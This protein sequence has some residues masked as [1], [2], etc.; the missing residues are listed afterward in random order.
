MRPL[1]LLP[2]LVCAALLTATAACSS[3]NGSATSEQSGATTTAGGSASAAPS[4]A[5]NATLGKVWGANQTGYGEIKPAKIYNGGAGVLG[6]VD[7]VVWSSWGGPEAHAVGTAAW[8]DPTKI[9]ADLFPEQTQVVAFNL[10]TCDGQLMYQNLEWYFPQHGE[11]FDPTHYLNMCTG[12]YVTGA[13]TSS[14][15]TPT[16]AAAQNSGSWTGTTLTITPTSLGVVKVGMTIEQADA[17]TGLTFENKG[18]G[19]RGPE[20]SGQN[21]LAVRGDPI[22]CVEASGNSPTGP[23]VM[24]EKGITLGDPES[25]VTAA[26][27]DATPLAAGG[28]FAR[29]GYL[30]TLPGGQLA[31]NVEEGIVDRIAGGPDASG[32]TC[33]G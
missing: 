24:T 1:R 7:N 33:P 15:S 4:L 11:A 32:T 26:Y 17:A 8:A 9:E 6:E 19:Q 18:D 22:T 27:P 31:I 5:L 14:A 16:S 2:T 10:G 30:V 29:P 20:L 25:K 23:T 3:V 13:P 12:Q 21:S 28:P